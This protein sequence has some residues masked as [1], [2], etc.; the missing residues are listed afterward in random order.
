[1]TPPDEN[2]GA[3]ELQ[4]IH[5]HQGYSKIAVHVVIRR[6]GRIEEGRPTTERGA[7]A[8]GANDRSIQVCL[9]GGVNDAHEPA[10]NFTP[11]QIA[12]FRKLRDDLGLPV[13]RGP[14]APLQTL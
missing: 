11:L 9:I 14:E 4:R 3:A 7:M 8:P 6:D 1:M 2:I 5:R 12:A 10:C 13:T